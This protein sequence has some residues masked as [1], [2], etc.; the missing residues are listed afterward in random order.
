[1]SDPPPPPEPARLFRPWRSAAAGWVVTAAVLVGG[2]PLFLCMPPWPDV[3]LYDIAAR[4]IL[5]G[6]VHY[7]DVFD[8]NLPGIV[9]AMAAV[10]ATCGWSYEALRAWDLAIVAGSAAVLAAWVRRAGG[11]GYAAA[12]FVAGVALFYPFT[13]EFN[14]CQRD[15][16]MLLPAVAAGWLR[17]RQ[18]ITRAAVE[19]ALWGLAVWLKPHVVVP[20]AVVW[21]VSAVLLAR[22]GGAR[23]VAADLLGLLAGGLLVGG[24]G[25]LWLVGSGTWPYFWDV[26][27]NWNPEY[28]AQTRAELPDRWLRTFTYFPPWS[29]LHVAA[30]PAA[31]LGLWEARR[32]GPPA[33][34]VRALLGALYLG[35]LAQALFLQK[36]FDYVHVPETILAMAVLAGFRWAVGFPFLVWFACTGLALNL[37]GDRPAAAEVVR[38]FNHRCPAA[39]LEKHPLADPAIL[40]LW[41]RC[42]RE[43]SSPPLRDRLGQYVDVHCCAR[44]EE[45]TRVAQFL[46]TVDPPLGDG[47]LTCWHDSPHPLYLMLGLKPSTRYMHFGTVLTLKRHAG[48]IRDE[49]AASRQRYV[50]SDL[51][52]MTYRTADAYA[53]G[54]GGRADRLPGWFPR[55]QRGVFPWNQPIV[56]RAGRY[57]VHRVENPVGAVDIPPWDDLDELGPGE[58]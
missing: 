4:N 25:V 47:E 23:A 18:V 31:L 38:A 13:S 50:V 54:A 6:G 53:P 15:V 57:V 40:E 10:R 42:W 29:L 51:R 55:S 24:A 30:V 16:W 19:G 17:R 7:R 41:P 32:P 20:A 46:R 45:L 21:L 2:V 49:V 3:T 58:D 37:V 43:G 1:M 48:Q 39:D 36:G 44:W 22:S 52:R 34:P 14:H 26:F 11:P 8:T 27:T 33:V 35:W 12:W 5:Q 28:V 56:F 9:W